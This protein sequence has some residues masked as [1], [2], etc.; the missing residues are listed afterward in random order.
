MGNMGTCYGAGWCAK[1]LSQA[2]FAALFNMVVASTNAHP[3]PC[4]A[5]CCPASHQANCRCS[6]ELCLAMVRQRT[7]LNLVLITEQQPGT[8]RIMRCGNQRLGPAALGSSP[9]SGSQ[10]R[11]QHQLGGG[12]VFQTSRRF[13][14]LL[15]PLRSV[16]KPPA[17][18]A[19]AAGLDSLP[20]DLLGACLGLLSQEEG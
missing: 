4:G 11:R 10:R 7:L 5:V 16:S 18:P 17:M 15:P 1:P 8:L 9:R 6:A 14:S 3:A 12:R 20:D 13:A 19:R 2:G